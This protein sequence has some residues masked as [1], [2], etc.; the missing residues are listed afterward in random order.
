MDNV[1]IVSLSTFYFNYAH[2]N[3]TFKADLIL[4]TPIPIIDIRPAA[5]PCSWIV[6]NAITADSFTDVLIIPSSDEFS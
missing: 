3:F 1:R 4:D 5:E 2:T 6:N